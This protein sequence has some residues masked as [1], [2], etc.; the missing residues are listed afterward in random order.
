MVAAT[1]FFV[2]CLSAV[3]LVS[4]IFK[5]SYLAELKPDEPYRIFPWASDAV[6]SNSSHMFLKMHIATAAIQIALIS[7]LIGLHY[8]GLMGWLES[9]SS[10]L[11]HERLFVILHYVFCG[12]ILSNSHNLFSFS[13]FQAML[14]N[15]SL[16]LF[17]SGLVV[18]GIYDR[19]RMS[20]RM[21]CMRLLYFGALMSPFIL[22]LVAYCTGLVR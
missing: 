8:P 22:E 18:L 15:D 5:M 16:I 17:L 13:E 6:L 10:Q 3:A 12:I 4:L 9:L 1:R 20:T 21:L 19:D 2:N 11:V 14:I 7:S